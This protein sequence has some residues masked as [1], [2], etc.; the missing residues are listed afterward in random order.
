MRNFLRF[1]YIFTLTLLL[2]LSA[3][4]F[5]HPPT[6][7]PDTISTA[8]LETNSF[9]PIQESTLIPALS[10]E[11]SPT[12]LNPENSDSPVILFVTSDPC[13][14][15][16]VSVTGGDSKTLT[17]TPP[18]YD[19][20]RP[21]FSPDGKKLAFILMDGQFDLYVMNLD[22]SDLTRVADAVAFAWSPDSSQLVYKANDPETQ[23]GQI[24][25]V[26]VDGENAHNIGYQDVSICTTCDGDI[27]L[28]WSPDGEWIYS[29]ADLD[30]PNSGPFTANSFKVDGSKHSQLSSKNISI[31][32]AAA[33]S[34]DSQWAA[35]PI[36]GTG[37]GCGELQIMSPRGSAQTIQAGNAY[38]TGEPGMSPSCFTISST[39]WSPDGSTIVASGYPQGNF[40]AGEILYER[41]M[42]VSPKTQSVDILEYWP[43]HP[44]SFLWSPDGSNIVF[45]ASPDLASSSSA[46]G[47][48][49]IMKNNLEFAEYI[50]LNKKVKNSPGAILWSEN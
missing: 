27:D 39:T 13:L 18:P 25:I 24:E 16:A 15:K 3:C 30:F 9:P 1:P 33:W 48:L 35:L 11:T 12:S 4:Q 7:I 21:K 44:G 38:K 47:P 29:P 2:L 31:F 40:A 26:N 22:G 5:D 17:T 32:T 14:V 45:T 8:Q 34:P 23:K 43:G 28:S 10:S 37:E 42:L 20:W 19:C 49:V 41:I 6:F 46:D 50:V 36:P